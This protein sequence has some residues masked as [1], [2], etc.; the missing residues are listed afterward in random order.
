MRDTSES[1]L[2]RAKSDEAKAVCKKVR[3]A[4]KFSDPMSKEE[5]ESVE[6]EIKTHYDIFKKAVIEENAESFNAEFDELLALITE[7]N[8]KCKRL[9]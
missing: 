9:K 5:L 6:Y 1:L 8:N 7:R 4:F 2:A 3:D